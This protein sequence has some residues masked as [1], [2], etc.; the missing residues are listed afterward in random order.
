M[1]EGKDGFT[2]R[3]DSEG[4]NYVPIHVTILMQSVVTDVIWISQGNFNFNSTLDRKCKIHRERAE[5]RADNR[6]P[7]QVSPLKLDRD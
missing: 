3:L 7:R 2:L 4:R 6:L 1:D 5:S